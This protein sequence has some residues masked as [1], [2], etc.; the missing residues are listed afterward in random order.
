MNYS[1]REIEFQKD[2][3]LLKY[4]RAMNVLAKNHDASV[5]YRN[6]EK[7]EVETG[8]HYDGSHYKV[9]DG[10]YIP[11]MPMEVLEVPNEISE[12]YKSIIDKFYLNSSYAFLIEELK[13]PKDILCRYITDYTGDT[14]NGILYQPNGSIAFCYIDKPVGTYFNKIEKSQ[15]E[16]K[17]GSILDRFL[18]LFE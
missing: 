16:I 12:E 1:K 2:Q 13:I 18:K 15:K 14:T 7:E 17:K 5:S 3:E 10:K 6:E 9:I 11:S 8:V 4:I